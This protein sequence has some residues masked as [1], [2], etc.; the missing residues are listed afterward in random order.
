M[1]SQ[2]TSV[3]NRAQ[4]PVP[5]SVHSSR[6]VSG[7]ASFKK[8]FNPD[9]GSAAEVYLQQANSKAAK[10]KA[11][12]SRIKRKVRR[13]IAKK[14]KKKLGTEIKPEH[15][16]YSLTYGMMMGIRT[17]VGHQSTPFVVSQDS[18]GQLV[19]GSDGSE[20][21]MDD[22]MRVSKM[23][24][25]PGG[26][27]NT[28]IITPKHDLAHTFKFKDYS[29]EIFKR[30]RDCFQLD[31][32]DYQLSL[33]GGFN[34]IEFISNSKSGQFFFYSHDGRF[35]IKTQTKEESKFLRRILPHYY[36]YILTNPNTL[37]TRFYGMHRVK[38]HHLRQEMHFVI[39]ASV[40]D[41]DKAI[42]RTYDLKGSTIG[43]WASDKDVEGNGVLKDC[44]LEEATGARRGT[45]HT[46]QL[47]ETKKRELLGQLRKDTEF[48]AQVVLLLSLSLPVLLSPLPRILYCLNST[49]HLVSVQHS[50]TL[51]CIVSH[52]V[53]LR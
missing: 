24:F 51:H 20:L 48:L 6:Q 32:A 5:P 45:H 22:F 9:A 17:S 7:R 42:H 4:P 29:P 1:N 31:Q 23:V 50:F 34:Y 37:V 13:R 47:G 28:S 53:E 2:I 3:H 39:M 26:S 52:C 36:R 43:R 35:M 18:R 8:V 46:I 21:N 30:I 15:E 25:P 19:N 27:T 41:T 49:L 44:D 33:C 40:F 16:Q 14:K 38:M 10:K 11:M 12:S